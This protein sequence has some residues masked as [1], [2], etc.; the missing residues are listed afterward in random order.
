[1]IST[2]QEKDGEFFIE[3]TEEML[4]ITGFKLGDTLTWKINDDGSLL[5]F[6]QK[7]N[8]VL[9]EAIQSFKMRY[10]VEVPVDH[11]EYALDTVAMQEA[12]EFSQ[13]ALPEYIIS[14]R[15][16]SEEEAFELCDEDNECTRSWSDEQKRNAFFSQVS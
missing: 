13:L 16:I 7:T 3:L 11:P 8:L 12:K 5:L 6:K 9:V 1:M 14:H 2:V 15:V 4:A 10:L